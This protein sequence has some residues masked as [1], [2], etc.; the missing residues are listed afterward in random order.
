M[1]VMLASHIMEDIAEYTRRVIVMDG[2]H[3]LLDGST[4][5]IFARD[6]NLKS[7]GLRST[8]AICLIK[9]LRVRDTQHDYSRC[10]GC[11]T[12][13]EAVESLFSIY[14]KEERR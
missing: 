10:E 9:E 3:I 13:E 14:R 5:D 12:V 1:A 6:D 11:V 2:G 7:I 8:E 4:K